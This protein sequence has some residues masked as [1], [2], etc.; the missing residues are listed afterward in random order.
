MVSIPVAETTPSPPSSARRRLGRR[1]RW[2]AVLAAVTLLAAGIELVHLQ[3]QRTEL[4]AL[5]TQVAV[6]APEV[7]AAQAAIDRISFGRSFFE[8]RPAVLACLRDVT[9]AFEP[10]DG[11]WTTS[12][13]FRDVGRVQLAGGATDQ[14]GV[15]VLLDRMKAN[16]TFTDV[17]LL[18][19]RESVGTRNR[20][21]AFSLTF[22][23]AGSP[24]P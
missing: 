1:A 21:V 20:E 11:I 15:L 7:A 8:S 9:L 16:P 6:V 12:L 5:E 4:A 3:Q 18:D 19:L 22:G 14:R 2:A 13:V 10:L 24:T 17:T 23:F